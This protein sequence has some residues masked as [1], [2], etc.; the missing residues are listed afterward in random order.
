MSRRSIS[1]R[2]LPTAALSCLLVLAGCGDAALERESARPVR[3]V[4]LTAQDF[5]LGPAVYPGEI[6]A[7]H[8]AA[9]SFQVG[10]ELVERLVDVGDAV[11]EGQAVARLDDADRRL[12]VRDLGA[13]L[14]GARARLEHAET[15]LARF[16]D[17]RERG[18]V[19]AAE[20][21]RADN[22]VRVARAE[23]QALQ[24][25]L[26]LAQRRRTYT[27]LAA[28]HAGVVSAALVDPGE[29]VAAG[30]PI[31]RVARDDALEVAFDVPEHRVGQ[32]PQTV[33]VELWAQSGAALPA[34]VREIAAAADPASRTYR[35]RAALP[36]DAE[37]ARI[38]MSATVQVA[39]R[40]ATSGVLLPRSAVFGEDD[41]PRVWRIDGVGAAS[42]TEAQAAVPGRTLGRVQ[43][44]AVQLGA[45]SGDQVRVL[46]GLEP[47]Q[48]VVTAGVHDLAAGQPVSYYDS[49]PR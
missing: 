1:D 11:D 46:A 3:A 39:D 45:V 33:T 26:G 35:V 32:L 18:F 14:A 41:R 29:V 7:R 9:L 34:R 6:M 23:V 49:E 10:G 27:K 2:S 48:W 22:A 5:R 40:D 44:Q 8:E 38:G 42:R 4:Q 12:Q 47:G 43:P 28:P 19:S 16:R 21:D 30:Q 17:L 20:F 37:A 24:A 31:L 25:Q 13:R 36:D 15:D